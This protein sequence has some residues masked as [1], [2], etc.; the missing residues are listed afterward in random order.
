MKP[1]SALMKLKESKITN[2][3]QFLLSLIESEINKER[4]GTKYP[5]L[6][7][8]TLAIKCSHITEADIE[9]THSICKNYLLEGKGA[10]GK[11][12]FGSLKTN[13]NE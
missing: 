12:F 9:Y 8:R 1:I 3:R 7:K 2:R 5:P 11:C 10:Y 13:K 4:I 6:H